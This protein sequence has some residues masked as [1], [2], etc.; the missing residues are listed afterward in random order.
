MRT[1]FFPAA[2]AAISMCFANS[3][4]AASAPWEV[5]VVPY[6]W[7]AGVD[8]SLSHEGFPLSVKPS[9]SFGDVFSRLDA[10][11]MLVFEAHGD[12]WGCSAT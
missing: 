5:R 12:R 7:T 10:A 3:A 1:L 4:L 6:V 2:L 8:G 11:G 9:A